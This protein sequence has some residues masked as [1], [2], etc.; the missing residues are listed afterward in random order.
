MQWLSQLGR[1]SVIAGLDLAPPPGLERSIGIG[2][3]ADMMH[4]EVGTVE[5]SVPKWGG[6]VAPEPIRC[7]IVSRLNRF[8]V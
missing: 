1:R 2:E 8:L 4:E 5:I 3:L 7:G 6:E